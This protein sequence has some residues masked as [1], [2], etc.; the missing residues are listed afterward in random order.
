MISSFE[1]YSDR[2]VEASASVGSPSPP[3]ELDQEVAVDI[4]VDIVLIGGLG[5][6]GGVEGS[7]QRLC[8]VVGIGGGKDGWLVE[9]CV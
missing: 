7:I 9:G 1:L 4:V 3:L 2:G 5:G 6:E 8:S